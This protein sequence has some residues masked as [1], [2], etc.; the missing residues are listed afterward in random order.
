M[1]RH[2]GPLAGLLAAAVLLTTVSAA[3]ASGRPDAGC[4]GGGCSGGDP[5][6]YGCAADGV[7]DGWGTGS[8][9][10]KPDATTKGDLG[11]IELEWSPGCQAKWAKVINA[12]PGVKFYVVNQNG[13]EEQYQVNPGYDYAWSNMV[14]GYQQQAEACL[15]ITGVGAYCTRWL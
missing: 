10:G 5:V 12:K 4:S 11:T 3:Q 13:T 15:Y 9:P 8:Q 2:N 14:S 1:I 6:V 7:G